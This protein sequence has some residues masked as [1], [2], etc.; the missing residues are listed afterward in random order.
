MWKEEAHLLS[1]QS[2]MWNVALLK[3]NITYLITSK[4]EMYIHG[5]HYYL[6]WKLVVAFAFLDKD[7]I[8]YEQVEEVLKWLI[9][10]TCEGLFHNITTFVVVYGYGYL[11]MCLS[12]NLQLVDC[13]LYFWL[14]RFVSST[15]VLQKTGLGKKYF[16]CCGYYDL[17]IQL[18]EGY[19][20]L[21]KKKT[22][23]Q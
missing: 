7:Y 15:I 12:N 22:R 2:R 10:R 16:V 5:I 1:I 14:H 17:F 8:E 11:A 6:P 18:M 4:S 23:P 3:K 9:T 21:K 13:F 19:F 20:V